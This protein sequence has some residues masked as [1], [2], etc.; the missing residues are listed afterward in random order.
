MYLVFSRSGLPEIT[1]IFFSFL[2]FIFW[3]NALIDK[4]KAHVNAF[5]SGLFFI[6]AFF[7]KQSMIPLIGVYIVTTVY[8]FFKDRVRLRPIMV[9]FSIPVI[10]FL[11][12]YYWLFYRSNPK[13]WYDNYLAT[14]N[15][16][17]LRKS[18]L[19]LSY[20]ANQFHDF[21]ISDYWKYCGILVV[22]IFFTQK[23][24]SSK[25][26]F[27]LSAGWFFIIM[28]HMFIAPGKFGRFFVISVI[29]LIIL[30]SYLLNFAK[31]KI[32]YLFFILFFMDIL[33]NS[34]N[35]YKYIFLDPKYSYQTAVQ[36]LNKFISKNDLVSLPLHWIMNADFKTVNP[37]LI[38]PSDIEIS[39]FFD[40]YGWPK[41][42]S[43]IDYQTEMYKSKAPNYYSR[44]SPVKKINEYIIY[45]VEEKR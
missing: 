37:F 12:A 22:S 19:S 21:I 16:H 25:I 40:K 39:R 35:I 14:I 26:L 44:L 5:L 13:E 30:F 41:Y 36:E 43:I 20:L 2:S 15:I 38:T 32:K 18:F 34:F 31:G 33:L 11:L 6:L 8:L 29:P 9:G 23:I 27:Y 4:K 17:R 45:K 1:M 3:F 28:L 10:V 7:T 42:V 24:S